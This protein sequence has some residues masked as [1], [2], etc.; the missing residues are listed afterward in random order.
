[1]NVVVWTRVSSKEQELGYSPEAQLRAIHDRAEREGWRIIK[2]F[3]VTETGRRSAERKKFREMTSWVQANAKREKIGGILFHKLDR[4]CRNMRDAMALKDLED[5]HGVKLYFVENQFGDGPSGNLSF[6]V[7]VSVSQ[8]FSDNL[9]D[10]T[11]KGM[12]EK[13]EQGWMPGRPPYGYRNDNEDKNEPIKVHGEEAHAVRRIFE[14]YARGDM[15]FDALAERLGKDGLT[16]KA[17]QPR[18]DRRSLSYILNNRYFIGEL[19]WHGRVFVGR[20]KPLIDR[21]TFIACQDILHG[22]N[23]RT[24]H[25]NHA[26]SGGLLTCR[27]C[28]HSLTGELVRKPLKGGGV[29]EHLYYRCANNRPGADHPK[30]RWK[31]AHLESA[32]VDALRSL[33]LPDPEVTSWFRDTI[34][35]A[36]GDEFEYRKRT[37]AFMRKR[38]TE[39]EASKERLL[40]A[41]ISGGI[42]KDVFERKGVELKL[43]LQE[44]RTKMASESKTHEDYSDMAVKVFDVVQGAPETWLGSNSAEKREL[45]ELLSLNREV[46]NVSLYVDWRKPFDGLSKQPERQIGIPTGI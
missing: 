35:A 13:A 9:R 32:I 17:D 37:L 8:F 39:L 18:F 4:A 15:T 25:C 41:H 3:N 45:L 30:V 21:Q 11:L 44:L 43:E 10:E 14:L 29:R 33:G 5:A 20:H 22:R 23:R 26:L 40:N 12:I 1:M 19:R 38:E 27:F 36:L 2:E 46:D 31:A 34:R 7:L 42:D 16:Y 28:G 24:T 6:N